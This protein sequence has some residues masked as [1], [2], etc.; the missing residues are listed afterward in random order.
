MGTIGKQPPGSLLPAD[1]GR[2][3]IAGSR[4]TDWE[5]TAAIIERFFVVE[6]AGSGVRAA[7]Q[8][9]IRRLINAATGRRDD[10]RLSEEIAPHIASQ[11]KENMGAGMVPEEA[12]RQARL[13]FG[14]VAAVREDYHAEASLPFVENLLLD[15]RYALRVLRKSPAFTLVALVTLMLGIG[16]NAVVFGVLNAVVLRP[17]DV[18]DPQ[19]LYQMRHKAWMSG[20]LLTT[21]YPAFEDYRRRNSTFS[22]MAGDLWILSR[23]VAL[24]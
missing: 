8:R 14:A 5:Q 15:I 3:Q 2:T 16:A 18:S 19:S 17:L 4:K 23:G 24:G 22:G 10:E 1:A 13:K 21:S 6:S 11:T 12:G 7:L 20:R 9:L